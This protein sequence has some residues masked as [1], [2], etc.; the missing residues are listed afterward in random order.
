MLIKVIQKR[1]EI[2]REVRG[3]SAY[4]IALR[5]VGKDVAQCF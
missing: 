5:E 3:E 2:K 4:H 1:T